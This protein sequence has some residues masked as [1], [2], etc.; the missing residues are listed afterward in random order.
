[1]K[2]VLIIAAHPD[3]ELLGCGGT[4]AKYTNSGHQVKAVIVCE[5]ESI[6]YLGKNVDQQ[7]ATE[8]ARVCLGVEEVMRLNY[9]DQKL[10]TI[11][12]VDII[13]PLE[14]II[15]SYKPDIVFC[16]HGG[17]IN[18]DHRI[19]Y[20][21]AM[22]ALRP[23]DLK[24]EIYSFFTVGSTE[25]GEKGNFEPDV[26]VDI[27]ETLEQKI[28]AF[29]CYSSEIREYPH[30]RSAQGLRNLAYATGNRVSL[31]AA[32]A[33]CTIRRVIQDV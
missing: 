9:P 8:K 10:D 28:K 33:F 19:V 3:D 6:R 15:D 16:Q 32:E 17:D 12:L 1:M 23:L 29:E 21:A 27:E 26:W 13:S 24:A 18:R 11:S 7:K 2:R 5:G 25:W 31:R 22:V 14:K 4:I 30:P 20:E